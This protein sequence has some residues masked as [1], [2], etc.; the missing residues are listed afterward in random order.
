VDDDIL[1]SV[2]ALEAQVHTL[3]D[4]K[5]QVRGLI[6]TV[7]DLSTKLLAFMA[8][9]APGRNW[10]WH[11]FDDAQRAA[12]LAE[13]RDWMRTVLVRY[14]EVFGRLRPCWPEHSAALD[15]LSAAYG[16][17][18][19]AHSGKSNAEQPAHWLNHWLPALDGQLRESLGSCG[20]RRHISDEVS[21]DVMG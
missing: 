5:T 1:T 12:A 10:V 2:L 9:P 18:V 7:A 13:L 14:P 8:R 11:E 17:W 6:G 21:L 3:D 15:G 16:S 20:L 19:L 4:L